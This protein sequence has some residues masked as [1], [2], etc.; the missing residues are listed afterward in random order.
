MPVRRKNRRKK[1]N[2]KQLQF[3]MYLKCLRSKSE[4]LDYLPYR[5]MR[6]LKHLLSK[7]E[8]I[9]LLVAKFRL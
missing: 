1:V 2:N 6:K 8:K 5:R 4:D 7:R 9:S 3:K